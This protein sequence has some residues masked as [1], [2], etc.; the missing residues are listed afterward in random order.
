[1]FVNQPRTDV[2]QS[3]WASKAARTLLGHAVQPE[4]PWSPARGRAGRGLILSTVDADRWLSTGRTVGDRHR[5]TPPCT[6]LPP[7][8]ESSRKVLRGT[9]VVW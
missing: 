3:K 1:M 2:A 6:G 8:G 9:K 5:G 7:T 4:P